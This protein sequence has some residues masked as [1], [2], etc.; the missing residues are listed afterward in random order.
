MAKNFRQ[1]ALFELNFWLQ[2]LGDHA[3]FIQDSLA[4]SETQYISQAKN[5]ITVFDQ[6]LTI[7]R[8]QPAG[9]ELMQ[10]LHRANKAGTEIRE[11]K[12]TLVRE[13]LVGEVKMTLPPS[14]LSHMVNELEEALRVFSFF[15][16]GEI[17]PT[18][19][20]LHHD[21]LWLLDAAGHAGAFLREI[22]EMELNGGMLLFNEAS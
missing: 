20:P 9:E 13:H 2:V 3:R 19:H 1:E 18:V 11:L 6:L 14:F 15:L 4:P 12:L 7:S 16:K 21:L 17:P 8:R 10:L 22:E 5:F